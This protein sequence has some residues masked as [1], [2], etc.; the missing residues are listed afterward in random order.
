MAFW[1]V[2]LETQDGAESAA[3]LGGFACFVAAGLGVLGVALATL[4][5]AS[6]G[7]SALIIAVLSVGVAEILV[8]VVAG[9]R[10][11]AG[12]GIIWGTIAAILIVLEI[13]MKLVTLTGIPGIVINAIL[14]IGVVNGIRGARALGRG[15]MT[16]D[17]AGEVFN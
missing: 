4:A 8:F 5:E 17:E 9:F 16:A 10:L 6:T 7:A 12:K 14:L 2:D 3:Q 11:R 15:D 1:D 13:V